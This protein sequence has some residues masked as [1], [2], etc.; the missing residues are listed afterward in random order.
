VENCLLIIPTY[1]RE[2]KEA[3]ILANCIK[4]IRETTEA[5]VLLVDDCS[6]NQEILDLLMEQSDKKFENISIHK[7]D[8]NEG[9]SRTVN[10]GLQ[11]ALDSG[12]DACLVNADIEF[13]KNNWLEEFQKSEADIVGALLFY[14]NGIIQHGG[15]GFSSFTRQFFHRYHGA[16]GNTPAAHREV[17]CP[18]T[19]ALQYI[20]LETLRQIG[21]YDENF[22]LSFEDVDYNIRAL[23]AGLTSLY[24]PKVKAIHHESLFRKNKSE[25]IQQWEKESL[26]LLLKK[27]EGKDF[28]ELVPNL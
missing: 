7:K 2:P 9:F 27:Y 6:P 26:S 24:N 22:R 25:K 28:S 1:I 12:R 5:E 14:P 8:E 17:K 20:R 18:V 21:L 23:D 16:P 10:V 11:E 3:Q 4:S 19:G 13:A 15:I